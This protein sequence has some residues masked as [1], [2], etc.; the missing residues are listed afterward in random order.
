MSGATIKPEDRPGWRPVKRNCHT[1][2][3][4]KR[5]ERTGYNYCMVG[6]DHDLYPLTVGWIESEVCRTGTDM[7]PPDA[8]GCPGW[9]PKPGAENTDRHYCVVLEPGVW[10]AP[11]EGD[12]GRTLVLGS[13]ERFPTIAAAERALE[14]A[15][16][17]RPFK[18]AR[19]FP[20]PDT[21]SQNTDRAQVAAL[22]DESV[23]DD[24]MRRAGVD[25][26]PDAV[27]IPTR[28]DSGGWRGHL[29]ICRGP[30][31]IQA[32][33]LRALVRGVRR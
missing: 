5:S 9:K 24:L 22:G 8:D 15:R 21:A 19:V 12:P 6:G 14:Q 17:Y 2:G 23:V 30:G 26:V 7:P 27:E 25:G 4:N 11:W 32:K 1:C 13:A 18:N 20:D 16:R 29:P 10:I 28:P 31:G 3:W 33:R